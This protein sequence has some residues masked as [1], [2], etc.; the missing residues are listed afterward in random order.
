MDPVPL[1]RDLIRAPSPSGAES[2]AVDVLLDACREL[3]FDTAER[4]AAGN[5]I[6][7][8][9]RG[10]GPTVMLNGHL[11]TVPVGDESAWPHPP[12]EA[13]V[14][15]GRVWGRGTSDMKSSVACMAVAAA[16]LL[17]ESWSGTLLVT[18]VV[19]EEVGGL[20]ARHLAATRPADA[21]VLGEPSKLKLMLGHRGRIEVEVRVPG[22]IAHAAKAELGRNALTR[23]ARYI[24]ALDALELPGGPPLGRSTATPT[25]LRSF[26]EDGPNV[27]PG[28]VRITID[29]RNH[30]ADST[31]AVL[32]R[33]R[34]LDPGVELVVAEE[35][36]R[37]E[38]GAVRMDFPRINPPYLAPG[39][40]KVVER[41]RRALAA[42]LEA[43]GRAFAEDVWWFATDA[44]HL[45]ASGAVIVGFGPGEEE[46]AHTTRESV[47]IENLRVA[48]RAY[49]DLALALLRDPA[50]VGRRA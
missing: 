49:R 10:D 22:A 40:S 34:A 33:L 26:P 29:Y 4:D 43:Q 48:T 38:D 8:I 12:L 17:E 42:S 47:S 32:E 9:E 46:L 15:D 7:A 2:P 14:A 39:E 27:V 25:Q 24:T 31:E 3:G 28:E 13:V 41:S 6:A 30:P 21:I 37:S 23:A 50:T 18:G 20:G 35:H 45:S 11:D 44:P 5:A 16:A 36:A 19:Q 1:T